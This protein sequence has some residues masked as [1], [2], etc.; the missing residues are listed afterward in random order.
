VPRFGVRSSGNRR[1]P[2]DGRPAIRDVT[3]TQPVLLHVLP[4][5]DAMQDLCLHAH[6]LTQGCERDEP[7]T[8]IEVPF[9]PQ[10]PWMAL[11]A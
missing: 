10:W 2:S 7:K 1:V 3:G 9:S 4:Q 5:G 11:R 6:S 8:A